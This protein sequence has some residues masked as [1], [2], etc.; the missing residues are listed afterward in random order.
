M[1]CGASKKKVQEGGEAA[2]PLAASGTSPEDEAN[3]SDD[4]RDDEEIRAAHARAVANAND[5]SSPREGTDLGEFMAGTAEEDDEDAA[6]LAL[7]QEAHRNASAKAQ[8]D[9]SS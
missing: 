4:D 9:S 8:A 7:I 5:P 1:G 3:D 6:E 2:A